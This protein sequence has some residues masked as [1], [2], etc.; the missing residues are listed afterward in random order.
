MAVSAAT[1]LA[2]FVQLVESVGEF[3]TDEQWNDLCELDAS[4]YAACQRAK[5]D[6]PRAPPG[7]VNLSVDGR[8]ERQLKQLGCTGLYYVPTL[9]GLRIFARSEWWQVIRQLRAVVGKA[10]KTPGKRGRKVVHDPKRDATMADHWAAAKASG[11]TK[12][13]FCKNRGFNLEDLDLL[14]ARIRKRRAN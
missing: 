12:A 8:T 11:S 1:L 6:V 9:I 4:L 14:L 5:I 13:E 7:T 2:Q 3:P 10:P